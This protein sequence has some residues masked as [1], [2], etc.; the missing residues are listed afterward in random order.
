MTT[1]T[2]RGKKYSSNNNNMKNNDDSIEDE[3]AEKDIS[4]NA[5]PE[6]KQK[7]KHRRRVS[8]MYSS[9]T[10]LVHSS[11]LS[12]TTEEEKGGLAA[13]DASKRFVKTNAVLKIQA[14]V[15][16]HISRKKTTQLIIGL[17]KTIAEN[18]DEDDMNNNKSTRSNKDTKSNS[19]RGSNNILESPQKKWY[20]STFSNE[21]QE[22][23]RVRRESM[24][25]GRSITTTSTKASKNVNDNYDIEYDVTCMIHNS[26]EAD[27]SFEPYNRMLRRM[28]IC[29]FLCAYENEIH[30]E[31]ILAMLIYASA[32]RGTTDQFIMTSHMEDMIGEFFEA[33]TY[34]AKFCHDILKVDFYLQSCVKASRKRSAG[35]ETSNIPVFPENLFS[36]VSKVVCNKI[37]EIYT[38]QFKEFEAIELEKLEKIKS[39]SK[40]SFVQQTTAMVGLIAVLG[41]ATMIFK[42]KQ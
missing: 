40:P 22:V 15:R 17:E 25:D 35:D 2:R 19:K 30:S 39:K 32:K 3:E 12:S 5:S 1:P 9:N 37:R 16:G 26:R 14:I 42:S 11:S 29:D 21:I 34:N 28:L 36:K 18:S 7:L 13:N 4:K 24:E 23:Q 41:M 38:K 20:V 27:H 33:K 6:L 31:I 10:R 8:H